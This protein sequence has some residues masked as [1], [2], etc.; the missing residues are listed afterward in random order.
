MKNIMKFFFCISLLCIL[1]FGCSQDPQQ[2]STETRYA[3]AF[4]PQ[5]YFIYFAD[6]TSHMNGIHFYNLHDDSISSLCSDPLCTHM[7][8]N[9]FLWCKQCYNLV[10]YNDCIYFLATDIITLETSFYCYN[11]KT[12]NLNILYSYPDAAFNTIWCIA[13]NSI[14]FLLADSSDSRNIYSISLDNNKIK[15]ITEFSDQIV[16]DFRIVG[17]TVFSVCSGIMYRNGEHFMQ[18]PDFIS[19]FNVY[20]NTI[21]FSDDYTMPERIGDRETYKNS[22][23]ACNIYRMN[24]NDEPSSRELVIENVFGHLYFNNDLM[25]F[26][27]CDPRFICSYFMPPDLIEQNYMY[28]LRNGSLYTYQL[29]S[30]SIESL[31]L[32]KEILIYNIIAV[33]EDKFV[34][35]ALPYSNIPTEASPDVYSQNHG[36]YVI[37]ESG[38]IIK[39]ID[40]AVG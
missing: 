7:D 8:E 34:V 21:Y 28:D 35:E 16:T 2:Y 9:C 15:K 33:Y 37:S 36:Y 17:E 26:S 25:Y 10:N 23:H 40:I 39:K 1:L 29:S 24:I 27:Y 14:Y 13:N 3:Q 12:N 31:F 5:D 38:D 19:S 20:G 22:L 18:M 6:M 30:Q 32:K 11:L 4:G